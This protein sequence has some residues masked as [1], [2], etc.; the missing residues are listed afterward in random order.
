MNKLDLISNIFSLFLTSKN[1]E[2]VN[3]DIFSD[4]KDFF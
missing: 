1:V 3:D 2:R 4:R